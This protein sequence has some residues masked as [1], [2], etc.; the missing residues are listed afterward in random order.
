VRAYA[1]RRESQR[2][3]PLHDQLATDSSMARRLY[4][5]AVDG[6]TW[7][8][9]GHGGIRGPT[10][11]VDPV[12]RRPRGTQ[13]RRFNDTGRAARTA[14][15]TGWPANATVV[16][17]RLRHYCSTLR[18][19][20]S[21]GGRDAMR[22]WYCLI[23]FISHQRGWHHVRAPLLPPLRLVHPA[24]RSCRRRDRDRD[25]EWRRPTGRGGW[26]MPTVDA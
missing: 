8:R 1:D 19:T 17:R 2:A 12:P 16:S 20:A 3:A 6:I 11:T 23:S 13:R 5:T 25:D 21:T 4:A 18:R 10:R 24:S 22:H 15:S 26:L 14:C 9:T 7:S